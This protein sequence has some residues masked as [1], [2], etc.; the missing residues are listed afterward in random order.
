MPEHKQNLSSEWMNR[1]QKDGG[2]V[3]FTISQ[4]IKETVAEY[5]DVWLE[6][7]YKTMIDRLK[8]PKIGYWRAILDRMD[9]NGE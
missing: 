3:T 5:P 9:T 1:W 6:Q 7:A 2:V 4:T 8:A